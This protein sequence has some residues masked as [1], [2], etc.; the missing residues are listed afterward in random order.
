MAAEAR[1][2]EAVCKEDTENILA[3]ECA[4]C[5]ADRRLN[6]R[7]DASDAHAHL[8]AAEAVNRQQWQ[9]AIGGDAGGNR[10]LLTDHRNGRI[11]RVQQ[12]VARHKMDV[13][14]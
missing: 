3:D 4:M 11:A 2:G 5:A 7:L 9:R 1:D 6:A 10:R 13:R 12:P 8:D 14:R